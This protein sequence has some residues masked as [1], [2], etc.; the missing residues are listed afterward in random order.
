MATRSIAIAN[1]KGGV[2]KTVT[3][4]NLAAALA[5]ADQNVL[6]VD[7]DPQANATRG[8]GIDPEQVELSV[9]DLVSDPGGQPASDAIVST[10]WEGLDVIASHV[11]LAGA[12]VELVDQAGREDRLRTAL[13]VLDNTYDYILLDTPPSLSLLTVN[14][15]AY[16]QQVL[17]PCQTHPYSFVALS[18]L[19]DTL[20]AI[21]AE[22]NP[23]IEIMGILPTFFD[24]R[25]RVS[26]NVLTQL[27]EDE[28]YRDRLFK[29]VVRVNTTI[30]ESA[31]VGRPVVF[32]RRGSYGAIDYNDLA[33]ELMERA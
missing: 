8:L 10:A 30:A 5:R 11:D 33:D 14:V 19:Y 1:E 7:M 25:T 32:Y 23:K 28:R 22:I 26:R 9:Y 20:E 3:V 2:G 27:Q 12:E 4:V 18:E 21:R 29:T 24:A 6:V 13:S 16:A 17:I 15:F 31:A